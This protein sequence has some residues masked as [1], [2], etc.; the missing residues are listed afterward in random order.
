MFTQVFD[1]IVFLF[2][3]T[4]ALLLGFASSHYLSYALAE[5][6]SEAYVPKAMITREDAYEALIRRCHNIDVEIL[7]RGGS[8]LPICA[9]TPQEITEQQKND[10]IS[11]R[12]SYNN[13]TL[14]RNQDNVANIARILGALMLLISLLRLL[15]KL[16]IRS[17][18]PAMRR[19]TAPARTR[20]M[21]QEFLQMKLLHENGV[22]S[23][24][25]FSKKKEQLRA[26]VM[27]E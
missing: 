12:Q 6:I 11:D 14:A 3:A 20:H 5:V 13:V 9:P 26:R 15:Y 7:L 1:E 2:A 4:S 10:L 21:E 17:V 18:H 24:D 19:A 27:A 16:Y 8:S 23:D 25:E 22:I